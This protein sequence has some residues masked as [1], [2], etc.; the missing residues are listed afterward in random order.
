M[1]K[2]PPKR[3][4]VSYD[5]RRQPV[6]PAD[7]S[8]S[9]IRTFSVRGAC[10]FP[11]VLVVCCKHANRVAMPP[12]YVPH[13]CL[14]QTIYLPTLPLSP[15]FEVRLIRLYARTPL[16]T[17]KRKHFRTSSPVHPLKSMP[18]PFSTRIIRREAESCCCAAVQ[19][20]YP[21]DQPPLYSTGSS[22]ICMREAC[23][24]TQ[25]LLFKPLTW[26]P[27]KAGKST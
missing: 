23:R 2:A 25:C 21:A 9:V 22:T 15:A 5:Q 4:H 17:R 16:R 13:A 8:R 20:R 1:R 10:S 19:A 12:V 27:Q 11:L 7:T 18:P 26:I 24:R 14:P 3:K 6:D